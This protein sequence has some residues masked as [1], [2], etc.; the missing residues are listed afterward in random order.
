MRTT[1]ST[2]GGRRLLF[3]VMHHG[4]K[5]SSVAINYYMFGSYDFYALVFRETTGDDLGILGRDTFRVDL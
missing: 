3:R 5:A 1:S 4:M 2:L